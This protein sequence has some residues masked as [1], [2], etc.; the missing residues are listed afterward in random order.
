M[1]TNDFPALPGAPAH[2]PAQEPSRFLDIVKGTA[3]MK[4]DDDQ[5]TL[6]EDLSPPYDEGPRPSVP[7]HDTAAIAS[8]ESRSKS[9]SVCETPVVSIEKSNDAVEVAALPVMNGDVK[10][11]GKTGTPVVSINTSVDR[12]AGSISPRPHSLVGFL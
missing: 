9:S 8:P 5:D 11:G 12:E 2:A 6:P 10:A 7:D 3:K 4:L 1:E